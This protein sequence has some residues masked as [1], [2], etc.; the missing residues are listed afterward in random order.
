MGC[1]G[2]ALT[3]DLMG[4]AGFT[5]SALHVGRSLVSPKSHIPCPHLMADVC[6]CGSTCG[7]ICMYLHA[8]KVRPLVGLSTVSSHQSCKRHLCPVLSNHDPCFSCHFQLCLSPMSQHTAS[9]AIL[10]HP[11]L[12]INESQWCSTCCVLVPICLNMHSCI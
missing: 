7:Y 6:T 5:S 2:S 12:S 8:Y 10:S 11:F 9:S 3:P 1:I 4:M